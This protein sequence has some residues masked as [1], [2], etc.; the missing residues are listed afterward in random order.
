[1]KNKPHDKLNVILS[2]LIGEKGRYDLEQT[3]NGY[4]VFDKAE[5]EHIYDLNSDNTW[6]SIMECY[7]AIVYNQLLI[8]A[9]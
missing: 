8:N 6:D 5:E 2:Q 3:T 4:M 7:L 9:N 1:M